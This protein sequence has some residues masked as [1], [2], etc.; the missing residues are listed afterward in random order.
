MS[1][2]PEFHSPSS[3]PHISEKEYWVH[4]CVSRIPR[5]GSKWAQVVLEKVKVNWYSGLGL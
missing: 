1:I 5:Y 3:C 4:V 2:N